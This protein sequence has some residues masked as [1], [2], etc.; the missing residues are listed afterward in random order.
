MNIISY[1]SSSITECPICFDQIKKGDT[2]VILA[3]QHCFCY[4]CITK[5]NETE[6][7]CP[8]CRNPGTNIPLNIVTNDETASIINDHK[9]YIQSII[10]P[11]CLVNMNFNFRTSNSDIV[12]IICRDMIN[13]SYL[14]Y[15][16]TTIDS[17]KQQCLSINHIE[18]LS[19]VTVYIKF[20]HSYY[21]FHF[22]FNMDNIQMF[23]NLITIDFDDV[24]DLIGRSSVLLRNG[25]QQPRIDRLN[26]GSRH[27]RYCPCCNLDNGSWCQ[28]YDSYDSC[29]ETY[30]YDCNTIDCCIIL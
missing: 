25:N 18:N 9:A 28:N 30:M 23:N 27:E 11:T 26:Y 5:W 20:G 8:I 7:I 4:E 21:R 29:D 24:I 22:E 10:A 19:C 14:Q 6:N 12:K 2:I 13:G 16:W 17:M 1:Q 15:N 3:C